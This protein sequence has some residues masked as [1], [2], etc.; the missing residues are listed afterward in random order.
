RGEE[1]LAIVMVALDWQDR[2]ELHEY[3]KRHKLN[4]PVLLGDGKVAHD[5]KVYAFPTYYVL[6]SEHRVAKRDIGYSTQ[7]GLWW[8][9]WIVD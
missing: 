2:A 6:D 3:S 4:V 7:L 9:S 8:R 1:E 5:W